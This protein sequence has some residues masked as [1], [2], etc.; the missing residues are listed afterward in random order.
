MYNFFHRGNYAAFFWL[1]YRAQFVV[2]SCF[3][4][5]FR[6]LFGRFFFVLH[7]NGKLAGAAAYWRGNV[8]TRGVA[9]QGFPRVDFEQGGGA[10]GGG[11]REALTLC[12][13]A[14]GLTGNAKRGGALGGAA[15]EGGKGGKEGGHGSLSVRRARRLVVAAPSWDRYAMP[16]YKRQRVIDALGRHGSKNPFATA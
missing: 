4:R 15:V 2:G 6:L 13:L 8:F 3:G 12:R 11:V 9:E 10:K 16:T 14:V 5:C 1:V 7:L